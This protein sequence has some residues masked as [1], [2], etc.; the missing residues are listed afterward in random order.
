M[1]YGNGSL[2]SASCWWVEEKSISYAWSHLLLK[3]VN[4]SK[5]T[6]CGFLLQ[7]LCSCEAVRS[8]LAVHWEEYL[9]LKKSVPGRKILSSFIWRWGWRVHSMSLMLLTDIV[10]SDNRQGLCFAEVLQTMCQMASSSRNLVTKSECCCDGGRGWG[11]QCELC[12]LPG[13]AQYKKICPHGP[14]YTTDG[15]GEELRKSH[16][17]FQ[18][19][20]H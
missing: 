9:P 15:R 2:L 1:F 17:H 13:T 8:M 18:G 6:H 20:E 12:P 5:G 19:S 14:G 16:A 4:C 7:H 10:I 3:L 11:H